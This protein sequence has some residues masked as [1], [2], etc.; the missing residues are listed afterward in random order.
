MA[1]HDNFPKAIRELK[2]LDHSMIKVGF[3][4]GVA[5][6]K[7]LVIVRANEYG[8]HIVPK[9]GKWLTIPSPDCPR[10]SDGLPKR[11]REIEGLFRPKGKN[12]LC[13]NKGGELVTY[14]YLKKEVTIPARP[15]I[16][17]A[18]AKNINKYGEIYKHGIENILLRNGTAA[19]LLARL[20]EECCADIR[21]SSI[22]WSKPPNAP[23][24]IAN[25]GANNPLVDTGMLQKRVTYQVVI[26]G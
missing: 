18:F 8:A 24:T 10:G 21:K 15:F 9:H 20:G 16:R 14:F 11:A 6:F 19:M 2:K 12:I 4:A 1:D 26:R 3:L 25:K 23:I 5:D 13:V 7:L 22:K 17:T